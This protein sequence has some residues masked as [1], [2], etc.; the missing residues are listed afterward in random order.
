MLART[1]LIVVLSATL[2]AGCGQAPTGMA[3]Q[4]SMLA[5]EA[6]G[7]PAEGMSSRL[8]RLH[9]AIF[10]LYDAD[11]DGIWEPEA[12]DL[13]EERVNNLFRNEDTDDDRVPPAPNQ[14]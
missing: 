5:A 7:E 1:A 9:G 4:R 10:D 2:L 6:M 3:G 12:F 8:K 11:S 14:N 13:P